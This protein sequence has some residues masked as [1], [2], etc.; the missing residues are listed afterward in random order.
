MCRL[1][2]LHAGAAAVHATFWLLDAPDNLEAQSHLN[3]DGV[4]IGVFD[5]DRVAKVDKQPVAAWDDMEFA[6]AARYL[7][8]TTFI[9]HVRHAT[10][11]PHATV[12]THPF[13]QNGRLFAHNGVVG[14]LDLL[15]AR[16]AELGV[17]DL[18]LGATDSERVF[19]LITAEIAEHDDDVTAGVTAAVGWICDHVPVYSLNFVLAT[20]TDLWALRYPA[21]NEL[22]VLERPA[23]GTGASQGLEARTD[24][25]HAR[26]DELADHSS[27]V[28]ASEPMDRDR[29]WRLL[30]SGE[31]LHIRVDL[32]VET[33]AP[34]P[35]RP[36]HQLSLS[37]MASV[38]ATAQQPKP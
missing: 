17:F 8:G 19:A 16:L 38:A 35:A 22:W 26:S 14:G 3:P 7:S 29:G 6:A 34:F 1:F 37:D 2:G 5:A 30:D 20:A 13:E 9:A 18:V 36:A 23:G 24:R 25:I 32:T 10:T 15:D 12:N 21:A 4:G 11:G 33:S 28:L 27:V 31:L